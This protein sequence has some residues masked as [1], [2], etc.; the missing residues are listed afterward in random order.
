MRR[1]W[2]GVMSAS[3]RSDKGSSVTS[4]PVSTRPPRSSRCRTRASVRDCAPPRRIGQPLVCPAAINVKPTAAKAV[5]SNGRHVVRVVGGQV[6]ETTVGAGAPKKEVPVVIGASKVD[7]LRIFKRHRPSEDAGLLLEANVS[8]TRPAETDV[9]IGI[10]NLRQIFRS[11]VGADLG[12]GNQRPHLTAGDGEAAFRC[13]LCPDLALAKG[14]AVAL[15]VIAGRTGGQEVGFNVAGQLE[16]LGIALEEGADAALTTGEV[17]L[18]SVRLCCAG[19][20]GGVERSVDVRVERTGA[21]HTFKCEEGDRCNLHTL[22]AN[23]ERRL[24]G[25]GEVL[26][27]V[28]DGLGEA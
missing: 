20:R 16:A 12:F 23:G 2:R 10:D 26:F 7:D 21:V 6:V 15:V 4:R 9:V 14:V 11:R 19:I 25:V 18:G 17:Q 22:V 3:T 24:H 5:V 8:V 28:A 1:S 13:S 27:G